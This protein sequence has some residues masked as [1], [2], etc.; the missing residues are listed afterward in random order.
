VNVTVDAS[1]RLGEVWEACAMPWVPELFT[2][3]AL[4]QLVD[5]RR[6]D[7]PV[8]VPYF[9]G[10]LAGEPDALVESFAG[11]PLLY[12]PVRGRV[13]GVAAFKAFA[14][15]MSD[16]LVQRNVSVEKVDHVVLV[17]GGFEEVVL[18]LDGENG[19]VALPFA[20]AAD[21]RADGRI[22][23]VR[24]YHSNRP[25]TGRHASRPPLLQPD[26]ELRGP[27]VVAEHQRALAAGDADAI[28]AVFESDGYAREAAG[29]EHVHRGRDGL[30]AFYDRMFSCGGGIAQEH[31]AIMGDGRVC[32][33]EYNV[34]RWGRAQLLPQAGLAV[35]VRSQ[36]GKLAAVRVYDDVEM[37]LPPSE[38][39]LPPAVGR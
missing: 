15:W 31:C 33:L 13:K 9:D 20:T 32:A 23:E 3:P 28:V 21:R 14:A 27:D 35:Y 6:R 29:A 36:S 4:Q 38:E 2:A 11:E 34:V 37:P 1:D 5:K 16:W 39:S 12:D 22:D 25:L 19:R 10:L 24:I 18:H 26:P 8:A 17:G 30:R 7:E